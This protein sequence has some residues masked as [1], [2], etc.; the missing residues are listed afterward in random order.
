MKHRAAWILLLLTTGAGPQESTQPAPGAVD[1]VRDVQ[2]I[3]REHCVACHGDKK[4]KGKLR[5]DSKPLALE[6][7]LSGKAILPGNGKDSR[8]VTILLEASPDDR[9]PQKS[10]PLPRETVDLLRRWIDQGASWPDSASAAGARIETHWSHVKPVR[11]PLPTVQNAWWERTSI[12]AF[13]AAG[14]EEHHLKPRP[15]APKPLLLRRVTL[16]LIGL[17]PT[18]QEMDAFVADAAPDAYEKVV[19]RLLADPRHGE[20]WGRHWMD[21]WRYSDWAGYEQ[22]VRDS[23]RHIWHW[24]DWIVE[25]VNADKPYDRMI[26][27]ML[28]GDELAPEDPDV[29]RA[30][31]FLARNWQKFSRDAWLQNVVEHTAK[32]FIGTTMNC[33][34]CHGHFFDPITHQEYYQFRAFFEPYT[35]RTDA[36]PGQA[37]VA[38]DG[39]PRAFD[40]DPSAPTYLYVRGN[41]KQPDK[42]HALPPAV[43][44]ALGG[45]PISI[46]TVR[47]PRA[48]IAPERRDFVLRDLLA[49]DAKEVEKAR[50]RVDALLQAVANQEKTL[51]S[52]DDPKAS[53]AL[54]TALEELPLALL[55]LPIAQAKHASLEAVTEAEKLEAA[56]EK[57]S[58]AFRKTAIAAQSAQR[59]QGL[60]ES[61]RSLLVARRAAAKSRGDDKVKKTLADAERAAE[62]AEAD[63][64]LP[65]TPEFTPRKLPSYPAESTGRRLALAR[66]I[67]DPENPLTARVAMNHLWMRH[68]GRPI[69]PTVFEFG[70]HGRAPSHPE[71]LDWLA[72]EFMAQGWS[73][74]KMHRLLV[75]SSA[76]R[77]DSMPDSNS[78]KLDPENK[79]LW[80]MNPRRMEAECVRDGV[81]YLSGALDARQGGPEIDSSQGLDVPRRSLYFRHAAEKQMGFLVLFDG[82]SVTECYERTESVVPQQALAMAN[83]TLLLETSRLLAAALSKEAPDSR[84]FVVAAFERILSR[85]PTPAEQE[86]CNGF[87]GAQARLLSHPGNLVPFEGGTAA[88]VPPSTDPAQRAREDL[89]QTLFNHNDFVMIR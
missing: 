35:V 55:A 39:L 32:A 19:D 3:L 54:Q 40:G 83:S 46:E 75:T 38:V 72:V 51:A 76:Y 78:L 44:R 34:R 58:E 20:R 42:S 57:N 68:F 56:G 82:A 25:S 14:L 89:V 74:K 36:I 41:E 67:A 30:T 33:A 24:R 9:M 45:R 31:G 62:K 37:D 21:V 48:A 47:L 81:L 88:K 16:D 50:T 52:G 85:A 2:P 63:A 69:V 61:R 22:E 79:W 13:I 1:F 80:R 86:E 77:M 53:A 17:P 4:Q 59:R 23:M 7:G 71:L 6:G 18:R 15:E 87:L 5:L 10:D 11:A 60:L 26:L 66:W 73:F 28:A 8:L 43:P 27:E 12:D 65:P 84:L 70:K 49:A 29:L 64:K